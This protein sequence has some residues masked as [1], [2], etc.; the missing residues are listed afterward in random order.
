MTA[1][2]A[3][4]IQAPSIAV[5]A[6]GRVAILN[7]ATGTLFIAGRTGT[8]A[9]WKVP[10]AYRPTH[11]V[12]TPQGLLVL[13]SSK[14][15]GQP[16]FWLVDDSGKSSA[17]RVPGALSE[18][19]V[20]NIA[21]SPI[22]GSLHVLT[23]RRMLHRVV[24]QRSGELSMGQPIYLEF[25]PGAIAISRAGD[26]AVVDTGTRAL[27]IFQRGAGQP[28]RIKFVESMAS[29]IAYT[30]DGRSILAATP[31]G[32]GI[33]KVELPTGQMTTLPSPGFSPTSL[34]AGTDGS[35]WAVDSRGNRVV[36]LDATGRVV[37]TRPTS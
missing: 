18:E 20:T 29:S 4:P 22:D 13:C 26:I 10:F 31:S 16:T 21:A 25:T 14:E 2:A 11:V 3:V 9:S 5:T 28:L 35:V 27:A 23:A 12:A 30:A 8:T 17:V 36:Q 6:D 15:R 7:T 33:V 32:V 34:A 19:I 24:L 37:Q 1:I